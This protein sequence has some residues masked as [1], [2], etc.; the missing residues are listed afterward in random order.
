MAIEQKLCHTVTIV[1][2]S[3]MNVAG[4]LQRGE[5]ANSVQCYIQGSKSRILASDGTE[6]Q[7]DFRI[8]FDKDEDIS[9]GDVI[10]NGFDQSGKTELLG[11][12]RIIRV[13]D[14]I[15]PYRGRLARTADV[16]RN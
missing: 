1:N 10:E 5:E 3:S 12:G 8:I 2:A 6:V 9:I 13:R 15:H 16:V 11:K 4:E 7:A 14:I